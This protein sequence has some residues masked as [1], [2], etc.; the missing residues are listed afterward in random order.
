MGELVRDPDV[1]IG[2]FRILQRTD[3]PF[4]LVHDDQPKNGSVSAICKTLEDAKNEARR[5]TALGSPLVIVN[6]A[7]RR[8]Q[9][10]ELAT[11][12]ADRSRRRAR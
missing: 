11:D 1:K 2:V 6:P 7:P 9:R 8:S 4:V 10:Q 5:L 3:G 12:G